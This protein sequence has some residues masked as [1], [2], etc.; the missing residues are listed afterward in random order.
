MLLLQWQNFGFLTYLSLAEHS[1]LLGKFTN[2]TSRR[3]MNVTSMFSELL[4]LYLL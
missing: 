2:L 3:E 1:K 4:Y